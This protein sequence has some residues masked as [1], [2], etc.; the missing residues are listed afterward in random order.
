MRYDRRVLPRPRR[1]DSSPA[2]LAVFC[3]CALGCTRPRPGVRFLADLSPAATDASEAARAE[4]RM[5]ASAHAMPF[6]LVAIE[7]VTRL[8]RL[9]D[10]SVLAATGGAL[11][12]L[13]REGRVRSLDSVVVALKDALGDIGS[14]G[15]TWPGALFVETY[16]L[17]SGDGITTSFILR[18]DE[19]RVTVERRL[20]GAYWLPPARWQDQ[21]VLTVQA[22][23][24]SGAFGTPLDRTGRL[25]LIGPTKQQAPR[26]PK[27]ALV[28]D[29]FVAYPS[30][31][32]FVLGG[33]R[34]RPVIETDA[35]EY[36]QEHRYMLDGAIVWQ[37]DGSAP[38]LRPV[39]LPETSP[40]DRLRG[41]RLAPGRSEQE[42]LVFGVLEIWRDRRSTDQP[43]LARFGPAGWRRI[44]IAAPI[45]R[46]DTGRDGAILAICGSDG[47]GSTD[48]RF[49]AQVT[50]TA[51]GGVRLARAP[52]APR[53]EWT[54]LGESAA[55]WLSGCRTLRP[56]E[57][58]VIDADDRWLTAQCLDGRDAS[59]TVLLHTQAQKPLVT[60]KTFER[61]PPAAR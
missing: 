19:R 58:V 12:A 39:Q 48:D 6:A 7:E 17:G 33:R 52:L 15:G 11:H 31:A 59:P 5:D 35:S 9:L 53:P 30:G 23:G 24:S 61:S 21:A 49:L 55:T 22:Q 41:G 54:A 26:L 47:Y 8:H 56:R 44:P 27:D 46:I 28:D 50:L 32:V 34:S 29:A 42:T 18:G 10:G 20:T 51:D 4:A 3:L 13:D 36:E 60:F 43:Y 2:W 1:L 25:V 14:V 45:L 40:R 57:L 38:A 37:T 16:R